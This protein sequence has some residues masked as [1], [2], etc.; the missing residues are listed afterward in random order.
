[1]RAVLGNVSFRRLLVGRLIT[2][3]GD[4][5]YLI[6]SLWIVY[7]LTNSPLYT[8][9]ASAML[10]LPPALQFLTGPL[11]DTWNPRS[12]LIGTQVVQAGLVLLIPV[13]AVTGHLSAP[14]V[15]AVIP[16]AGMVNQFYYPAQERSIPRLVSEEELA[17][18]N[19]LLSITYEGIEA[20]FNAVGGVLVALMGAVSLFVIDAVSFAIVALIFAT[21]QIPTGETEGPGARRGTDGDFSFREYMAGLREGFDYIVGSVLGVMTLMLA[22]TNFA[23]GGMTAALPLF[24]DARGGPALFG[25]LLAAIG[26]GRMIGSLLGPRL[27]EH[28]FGTI[29]MAGS[30][31]SGIAWTA[32]VFAEWVPLTTALFC[33]AMIPTGMVNVLNFTFIQTHVPNRMLGRASSVTGSVAAVAVPAGALLGGVVA[34]SWGARVV[35]YGLGISLFVRAIAWAAHPRLR[36]LPAIFDIDPLEYGLQNE[37][38][39]CSESGDGVRTLALVPNPPRSSSGNKIHLCEDCRTDRE[40]ETVA[41]DSDLAV[42]RDSVLATSADS[43]Q[44]C[45]ASNIDLEL[46][47]IVPLSGAGTASE[48]NVATLCSVCH[49]A[50]H[51]N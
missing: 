47:P 7:D 46:H 12:V 51:E 42:D 28:S 10:Y 37:C 31:F 50:L 48:S 30:T 18:A 21:L 32:G 40:N 3:A 45:G 13:A 2:N 23:F 33:I 5:L 29:V 44:C 19:S 4:S 39:N 25:I 27:Q 8:G 9:I 49:D 6:A 17:D 22:I 1:M 11:V 26:A 41:C 14:L 24:A 16:I 34:D 35:V 20:V 38:A 43:C 36:P 15:L